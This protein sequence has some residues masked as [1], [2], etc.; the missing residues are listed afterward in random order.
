MTLAATLTDEQLPYRRLHAGWLSGHDRGRAARCDPSNPV[1]PSGAA[2][3]SPVTTARQGYVEI[4]ASNH[5][6]L[7]GDNPRSALVNAL[8]NRNR[9]AYTNVELL[10][11]GRADWGL[12]TWCRGCLGCQ[13]PCNGRARSLR[14]RQK[15]RETDHEI[16]KPVFATGV[17]SRRL[18]PGR[19]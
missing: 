7:R 8:K 16:Y 19:Q 2:H 12:R 10:Q 11:A 3:S 17:A 15:H 6:A 4:D 14:P 18:L 1:R 9:P 5:A 13:C